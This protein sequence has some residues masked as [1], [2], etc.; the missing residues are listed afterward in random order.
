MPA[1]T[2]HFAIVEDENLRCLGDG[3]DALGNDQD[4]TLAYFLCQGMT[5]GR[6]SLEI[7]GRK[8]IVKDIKIRL[9]KQGPGNSQ[10]LFLAA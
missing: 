4:G 3:A 10:T 5:Q 7:E 9:F 8:A 6:I 2:G 1:Q